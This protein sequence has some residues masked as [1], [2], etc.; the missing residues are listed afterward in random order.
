MKSTVGHTV[1][2]LK[3]R[4]IRSHYPGSGLYTLLVGGP[5]C[6]STC[7]KRQHA[8]DD[9]QLSGKAGTADLE[10]TE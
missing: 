8:K 9:L 2:T 10:A 5:L 4:D 7:S 3:A 6:C 1:G